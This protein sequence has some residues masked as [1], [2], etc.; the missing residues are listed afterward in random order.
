MIVTCPSCASRFQY[1]DERFQGARSKR[2]RC[3][4][5]GHTFEVLNPRPAPESLPTPPPPAPTPQPPPP[6][7]EPQSPP[8]PP[9][10]ATETSRRRGRD[11]MLG[12]AQPEKD[13]MPAGTA[14]QPGLPHGSLRLLRQGPGFPRHHHR[15][16]GGRRGD[17]RPRDLP[18]PRPPRD[19]SRRL[20][21]AHGPGLHQRH[22]HRQLPVTEPT[23]IA[24]RQEF[25]CG[26]ST[27]MLLVRDI[28]VIGLDGP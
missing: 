21:L 11:A 26:R 4:R 5:C 18:P 28:N 23:R 22:L 10:K 15:P 3:P 7:P 14:V 24:D 9:P 16:G 6:P 13:G 25:S 8:Q 27:F 2:F 17:Q 19:P 1:G 20:G 12:L